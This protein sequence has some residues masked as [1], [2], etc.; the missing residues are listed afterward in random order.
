MPIGRNLKDAHDGVFEDLSV[1][2]L[3]ALQRRTRLFDAIFQQGSR[4]RQLAIHRFQ[5]NRLPFQRP[6][7]ALGNK[8]D[9][10][11]RGQ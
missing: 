1:L 9:E 4:L 8:G 10:A 11:E 7:D 6:A 2:L 3:R 5:L